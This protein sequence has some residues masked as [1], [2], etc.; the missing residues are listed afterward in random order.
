[1]PRVLLF[2]SLLPAA[3][4]SACGGD[5][6]GGITQP[7]N[8]PANSI[9]IV[10]GAETKGSQAFS[11]SPLNVPVNSVVHWYN[12]DRDAVG[13]VYG[14][15]GGTIH[16]INADDASFL[17]GNLAPGRH[18]QHTFATAGTYSYHCSIHLTMTGTITVGP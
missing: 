10:S 3:L 16:T 8:R 11:P 13:G 17:S 14:G 4:L 1:M 6:S 7:P 15:T 5:E 18:F 2:F 9:S 12:D